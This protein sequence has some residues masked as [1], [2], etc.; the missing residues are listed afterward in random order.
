MILGTQKLRPWG[1]FRI[2][3]H[4]VFSYERR[5]GP[6][7]TPA[8]ILPPRLDRTLR[9]EKALVWY[10]AGAGLSKGTLC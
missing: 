3:G 2:S 8:D 6:L 5:R 4:E 10:D 1:W 9:P 7:T